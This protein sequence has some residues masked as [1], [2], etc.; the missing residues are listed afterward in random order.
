VLRYA[1]TYL[2]KNGEFRFTHLAPGKYWLLA[3]TAKPVERPLAWDAAQRLALRRA[4]E[5]SGKP[6]ELQPCQK[7]SM[8]TEK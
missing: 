8:P 4:A 6:I 7:L 3:Q 5:T 2:Q 1:Q